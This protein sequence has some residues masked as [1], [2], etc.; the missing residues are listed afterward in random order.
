[1][2]DVIL[3]KHDPAKNLHRF[4]VLDV[5][6]DLFGAS[7]LICKWGRVG[8]RGGQSRSTPYPTPADAEAALAK[9]RRAKEHK[10]YRG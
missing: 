1:M 10:G 5:P 8:R 9:Q 6:P 4:Y 3:T 7:C 2:S